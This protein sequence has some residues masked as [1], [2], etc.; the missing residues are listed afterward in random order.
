MQHIKITWEQIAPEFDE[1]LTREVSSLEAL[2]T[3]IDDTDTVEAKLQNDFAWRYIHQTTYTT[4][5]KYKQSYEKFLETIYP[6][7]IKIS[8]KLGRKLVENKY[9]DELP[10]KY[11]NMI[12]S[13]KHA[14]A[15]YREEN[16]PL[17][18]QVQSITSEYSELIGAMSIEYN[19]K[20]LTMQQASQFL[21]N[22]DRM[23]R[24][25]VFERMEERRKADANKFDDILTRL[26]QLRTQIAQNAGFDTYTQYSYSSRFD[27]S[28]DDVHQFHKSIQE[29]ITPLG[30]ELFAI[31]KQKLWLN[32]LKPYDFQ[33]GLFEG[34]AGD[35]FESQEAMLSKVKQ[36]YHAMDPQFADHI[37]E[38][39]KHWLLDLE[40]RPGKASNG[41]NYPFAKS[42]YGFIFMN[43]MLDMR[44]W[45]TMIHEW[46]HALHHLLSSRI[47][48]DSLRRTPSELAEIASMAME[49]FTI[50][51]LDKI[52][53]DAS[54]IRS[55]LEEKIAN[56][57]LMFAR[58]SKVDLFQERLYNHP[59]HTVAERHEHR[60]QLNREYPAAM[61][62]YETGAWSGEYEQYLQTFWQRQMHIFEN[63]FYYIEYGLAQLASIQLYQ[64][65]TN[66]R[67]EAIT[68]YKN[69]LQAGYT[70]SIPETM[71]LGQVKFDLSKTRF[72]ELM[73]VMME[74]Y[75]GI[76][77]S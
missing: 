11:S 16:V 49:L 7:W 58:I 42:P 73:E 33:I 8:D 40:S 10:S 76:I 35:V 65:W 71:A 21:K 9:I 19:G 39:E 66:N 36:L 24:K 59:N 18:A 55:A 34:P 3:W 38:M 72:E 26:V 64:Q 29:V 56:D 47:K 62:T 46:W 75:R 2:K 60:M 22:P 50:D 63:P 67:E 23:V 57:F 51:D 30:E 6:N 25:E 20:T 74:K 68:N 45:F 61:R 69:I 53:L 44:A 41:Y 37:I 13:T 27:Y 4:S 15:L 32:E 5:E 48:V 43:D 1:L 17:I 54:A 12:R 77:K 52:W 70:H 28:Q 31:R 14:I